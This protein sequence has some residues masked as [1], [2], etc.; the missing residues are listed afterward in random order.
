M[1]HVHAIKNTFKWLDFDC[2]ADGTTSALHKFLLQWTVTQTSPP[3][4]LLFLGL[5]TG[6]IATTGTGGGGGGGGGGSRMGCIAAMG[7][8]GA[9]AA[10]GP[11]AICGAIRGGKAGSGGA[12]TCNKIRNRTETAL[13]T[14]AKMGQNTSKKIQHA[15]FQKYRN[16]TKIQKDWKKFNKKWWRVLFPSCFC[17]ISK[18]HL[19]P[20][21]VVSWFHASFPG[22][23]KFQQ[24]RRCQCAHI[25]LIWYGSMASGG[26]SSSTNWP[27]AA[28]HLRVPKI[29]KRVTELSRIIENYDEKWKKKF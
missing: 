6:A 26:K 14:S 21:P 23:A 19:R 24:T 27:V 9:K 25:G 29:F 4:F 13:K 16:F 18:K 20:K 1:E 17:N 22:P 7:G 15:V 5:L 3:D 12:S 28:S 8:R 2:I 10:G 11:D